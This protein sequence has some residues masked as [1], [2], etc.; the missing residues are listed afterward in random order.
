MTQEV[1][2]SPEKSIWG[3]KYFKGI[4]F[5]ALTIFLCLVLHLLWLS[6]LA[7]I[8]FDAYI[9]KKFMTSKVKVKIRKVTSNKFFKFG[10]AAFFYLLLTLWV[11]S[12]WM[13]LGLGIIYDMYI[14]QKV[15][16]AFWKKRNSTKKSAFV[17][18][19]DALVF[20]VI[21]ATF[22]RMFF[23]E[24]FTIPTSS[25]E[26]TLLV[27]D[28]LFVSKF[29]YGPKLPNTPIAFPF[30][31]HTMPFTKT[32]KSYLDWIQWPYKRLL[33]IEKIKNDDIVVFNF[34]EGDTV[35]LEDQQRN[36]YD[37]VR[38]YG[39]EYLFNQ[40]H[41]TVRPVDKKENYIK[42]CIG[43]PN[44]SIA[45]MHG[46]LFVNGKQQQKIEDMQFRY[47]IVNDGSSWNKL[48][49]QKIGLSDEDIKAAFDEKF[50][51]RV[52]NN[53][54]ILPLTKTMLDKF[55]DFK[56]VKSITQVETPPGIFAP[57]IFPRDSTIKWNE[58]NFGPLWIPKKGSSIKLTTK[59]LPMYKRAI[60]IYE[61]NDLEV[62]NG[63]IFING[64]ETDTY[65]FKMDYYFM[66]GD[67]RHNSADSRFWGMVPED[68]VVGKA[69][70][71][72]LSLDK[73]KSFPSNIRFNRMFKY[74]HK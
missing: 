52:P 70:F 73:D 39:R 71:I 43:I 20:A 35:V 21:A 44:D 56:N 10:V 24:A 46:L 16:W 32:T 72:W 3:N 31:H 54:I 61:D 68:H 19:V 29:N 28:Y 50:N 45:I 6:P 69:V 64:K 48:K 12:L 4:F 62:K 15:N 66:M 11:G 60:D 55:K 74:I 17:E 59:N 2:K 22:I 34:P 33:G 30:A 53:E 8:V 40:F 57:Y 5:S 67:S 38:E 25:M 36:Y 9:T 1:Q 26:K 58:D 42:R 65:T 23:I 27:G 37:L 14:T 63:K 51:G 47:R 18:W 49:L 13:L 41:I 7:L